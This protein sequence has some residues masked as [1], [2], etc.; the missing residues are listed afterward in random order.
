MSEPVDAATVFILS[1]ANLSGVG[2]G[3]A[4]ATASRAR[5]LRLAKAATTFHLI[6]I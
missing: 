5:R 1:P 2:S 3:E 6:E 4:G